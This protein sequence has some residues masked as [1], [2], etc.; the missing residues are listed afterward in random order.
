MQTIN[1]EKGTPLIAILM[2]VYEPRM[3]WLGE[4]LDSLEAQTYP[5]LKLYI[6]DDCSPNV[7]LAQIEA[8]VSARVRSFPYELRRNEK[9]LGSNGTLERL[10]READGDYFAYCDQDDVWLP[11]KLEKLYETITAQQAQLVCSDM[12]VIDA[13]GNRVAESITALRRHH[14]FKSGEELWRTLWYSNFAS[15][16][17]MLGRA[18]AARSALPF[19][20]HMVY[21]HYIA[22]CCS[23]RGR[24]VSVPEALILHREH[25]GNQSSLLKGVEDKQSYYRIRVE[26]KYRAVSWLC[27]NHVGPPE[28]MTTLRRARKWMEARLRYA[29]GDRRFAAEIWR[30]RE[31]SPRPALFELAMP[32]MPEKLFDYVLSLARNNRI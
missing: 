5:R 8:C 9:N 17:A 18:D 13:D 29:R 2:A 32:F 27:D 26:E 14:L 28:L 31:F 25:G 10:T 21:D 30:Q 15:G 7:S 3:D 23:G 4:Q 6:R 11:E 20:R 22:L 1:D 12:A 24:V 19:N 16:C